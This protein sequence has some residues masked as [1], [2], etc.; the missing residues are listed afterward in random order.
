MRNVLAEHVARRVRERDRIVVALA[1]LAAVEAVD[2]RCREAHLARLALA[3]LQVAAAQEVE[4]L[5]RAAQLEVTVDHHAVPALH[6]RVQEL[7]DADRLALGH[8]LLERVALEHPRHG[9]LAAQAQHV[10]EAHGV[11]PLRV[12]PHL[13]A[14]QVEHLETCVT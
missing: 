10:L 8:A 11:E 5:V 3:H 1:H 7:V 12:A 9:H 4:Q 6:E 2:Q 13:G 14:L